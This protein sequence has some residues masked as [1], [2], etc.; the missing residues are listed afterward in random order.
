MSAG[1]GD[2]G[3]GISALVVQSLRFSAGAVLE[4]IPGNY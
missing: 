1:V 2:F 3:K 4:D